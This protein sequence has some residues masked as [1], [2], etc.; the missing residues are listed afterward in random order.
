MQKPGC[1][2]NNLSYFDNVCMSLSSFGPSV[3]Q[4]TQTCHQMGLLENG[5]PPKTPQ[6][7]NFSRKMMI[8]K[9]FW[10]PPFWDMLFCE[11][12]TTKV[13]SSWLYIYMRYPHQTFPVWMVN[14][15]LF[16][17]RCLVQ[18]TFKPCFQT[19][20]PRGCS[21]M[22][23]GPLDEVISKQGSWKIPKTA[24][25]AEPQH[26]TSIKGWFQKSPCNVYQ[27]YES[28]KECGTRTYI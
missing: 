11:Y 14:L 10:D 3:R 9:W 20:L 12:F 7:R 28:T 1:G 15:R 5:A 6:N 22:R 2:L 18:Q 27:P 19:V 25:R 21:G 23:C 16:A 24:Q 17:G 4:L 13:T 26:G 8:I